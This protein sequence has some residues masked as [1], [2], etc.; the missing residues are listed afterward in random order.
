MRYDREVMVAAGKGLYDAAVHSVVAACVGGQ[1]GQ[2]PRRL[3]TRRAQ[4]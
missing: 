2:E 1:H 4:D 3:A